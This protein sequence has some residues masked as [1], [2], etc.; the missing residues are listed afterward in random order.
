MPEHHFNV[1]IASDGGTA[2]SPY[3]TTDIQPT[4]I[5]I[6]TTREGHHLTTT[7]FVPLD[8]VPHIISDCIARFLCHMVAE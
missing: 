1:D 4:F 5:V 3:D 7:S 6:V 2:T 8:S